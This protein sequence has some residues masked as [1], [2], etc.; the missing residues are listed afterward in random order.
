MRRLRVVLFAIFLIGVLLAGVGAGLTMVEWSSLEYGGTKLLDSEYLVTEDFDFALKDDGSTLIL[1]ESYYTNR[2]LD[3]IEEDPAVPEGIVRY[4]VTYN[5]ALVKPFLQYVPYD[6]PE[7][8]IEGAGEELLEE[9]GEELLIESGEEQIEAGEET[10]AESGEEPQIEAGEES[11]EEA[12]EEPQ[13]EAGEET[14]EEP[15]EEKTP[16]VD[17]VLR[18][19]RSYY[20]NEFRL[21][22]ENKDEM[23]SDLKKGRLSSYEVA[24]ITDVKILVNPATRPRVEERAG[25]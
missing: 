15:P 10:L 18:L 25:W 11:L 12:G 2:Y 21:F 19:M 1:G 13:I 14:R 22:M 7:E 5:Q 4:Q 24:D 17:G 9:S 20:G 23:L 16:V 6:R 3:G 8:T